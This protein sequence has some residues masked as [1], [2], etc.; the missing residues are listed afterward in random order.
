[1]TRRG[2]KGLVRE[3]GTAQLYYVRSRWHDS[4]SRSFLSD[5]PLGLSGGRNTYAYADNDPVNGCDPSGML[6]IFFE[7]NSLCPYSYNKAAP[8]IWTMDISGCAG[9]TDPFAFATPPADLPYA[10]ADYPDTDTPYGGGDSRPSLNAVI[11]EV[12]RRLKPFA[13][14]MDCGGHVAQVGY[15]IVGT[16]SLLHSLGK[17]TALAVGASAPRGEAM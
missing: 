14:A 4:Q 11:L 8:D 17:A 2:W 12:G 9:G 5:D 3:G 10:A 16:R 7:S 15:E 13:D 1:M 6:M